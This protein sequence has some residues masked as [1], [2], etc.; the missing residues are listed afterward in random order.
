[1]KRRGMFAGLLACGV[2]PGW[3][4]AGGLPAEQR[5]QAELAAFAAEDRLQPSPAGGVLFVGSSTIR[6]WST[7]ASDFPEQSPVLRRG[8]GGSRLADCADL[9][10]R[11]VWPYQ[12]RLVV[13][14][15]GENDL[16]EGAQPMELL[17]H[18]VRFAQQVHVA[19]PAT[20]VAFVSCKPSP[21][22]LVL[23]PAMR[24]V[25]LLIQTHVQWV[26]DRL[27]FIDVHSAMLRSDG[28]PRPEL[29]LSDQLHLNAEGYALWRQIISAHLRA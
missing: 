6:L 3:V 9:T 20:R 15:A 13:L 2:M 24:E 26:R 4:A 11:L 12:P 8:F 16:A 23:L 27:D 22:R 1:M 7:L 18:F 29:F 21:S 5:W 28:V 25:N 17:G 14:Y 10:H 19:L